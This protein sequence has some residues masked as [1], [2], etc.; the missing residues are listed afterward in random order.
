MLNS[1]PVVGAEQIWKLKVALPMTW[2][3]KQA[4]LTLILEAHSEVICSQYF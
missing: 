2:E 4:V 1:L 3:K